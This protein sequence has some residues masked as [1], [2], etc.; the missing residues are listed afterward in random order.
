MENSWQFYQ[1][2]FNIR[3]FQNH[4]IVYF[5]LQM[6]LTRHTNHFLHRTCFYV[7]NITLRDVSN[8]SDWNDVHTNVS[9]D[10]MFH[11]TP[12]SYEMNYHL[13]DF[14]VFDKNLL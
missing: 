3:F 13:E 5:D 8:D 10:L 9:N 1:T 4:W 12:F 2:D 14:I 11:I 6:N 7:N